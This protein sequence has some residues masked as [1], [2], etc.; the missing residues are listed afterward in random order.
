MEIGTGVFPV[1]HLAPIVFGVTGSLSS[2]FQTT[3]RNILSISLTLCF[4]YL[5]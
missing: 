4:E 1:L 3:K 5:K 2:E